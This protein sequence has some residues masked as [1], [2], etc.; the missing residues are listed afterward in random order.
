MFHYTSHHILLNILSSN[1]P[2]ALSWIA[3]DSKHP[4]LNGMVKIYAIPYDGVLIETELFNL[5]DAP[6]GTSDASHASFFELRFVPIPMDSGD[7]KS[8]A[9]SEADPATPP[10]PEPFLPMPMLLANQGYAWMTFY[11]T[12]CSLSQ[13]MKCQIE[14]RTADEQ[15]QLIATGTLRPLEYP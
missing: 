14:I 4:S 9:L 6:S 5:P 11:D 7:F 15:A 3:G 1:H 2:Q 12:R 13:L 10:I 8:A